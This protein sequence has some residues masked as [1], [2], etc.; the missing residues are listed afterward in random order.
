MEPGL[1]EKYH[2]VVLKTEDANNSHKIIVQMR[3]PFLCFPPQTSY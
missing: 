2:V 1:A 3:I